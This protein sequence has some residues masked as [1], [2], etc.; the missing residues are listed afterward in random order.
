MSFAA[1]IFLAFLGLGVPIVLLY[2]L[3]Q[4]RRRVE[5][6]TLMFWDRILRDEQSVTSLTRLRKLLSLFLQ[7]LFVLLL[8][9]ALARP[10]WSGKLT[11][12]RRVVIL[13]DTSASMSVPEEGGTRFDLARKSALGVIRGLSMGDS[14]MLV[15]V[16][17]APDIAHPFTDSPKALREAL[18]AVKPTQTGTDFAAALRLVEDLPPDPRETHVYLLTDGAFEPVEVQPQDR[19][20]FAYIPV[21]KRDSN[22]GITG[23]GVRSLPASPRDFQVHAELANLTPEDRTVPVELRLN[24]RL[25]DAFEVRVPAGTTV[26]RDLRQFSAEGGE[27]ELIADVADDFALDNRGYA[28]LPAPRPVPVRLVTPGHVFL[29]QALATDAD[30]ALHVVRPE[31]LATA[32]NEAAVSLFV[33]CR[34]EATPPGATVFVGDWPDDLGLVRQGEAAKPLFTEWQRE[35][36]VNRHLALQNVSVEKCVRVEARAPWQRLASSFDDPLL[37][38]REDA[39]RRVLVVTFDPEA[40]DLPL[41]VAFPMLVANAVRHFAQHDSSAQ[42]IAPRLGTRLGI[43]ELPVVPGHPGAST[44]EAIQAVLT[45]GGVQIPVASGTPVVPVL[46]AG[47]YRGVDGTGRTNALFAA[48]LINERESRIQPSATIP[49]RSKAPI[50]EL[51]EGLRLGFEPWVALTLL[52]GV[53]SVA[54]WVLFHR[55][56]I[57]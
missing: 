27:V 6:S 25:T 46:E 44:N 40:S 45:P 8:A 52:A 19:V 39:E 42:G 47:F 51:R 35:H 5:V 17:E 49:L 2:L 26:T 10:L 34:P 37:L 38:L 28:V 3:K 24:G 32:T 31:G 30:V 55:R 13:L 29:E 50:P 15:T 48:N 21:G 43:P 12:S 7:L 41:R 11:G 56:I 14:A 20:Q 23:F 1:P 4:R 53:L 36:P 9:F 18:L 57:E 16:A 54:E 33:G 22:V